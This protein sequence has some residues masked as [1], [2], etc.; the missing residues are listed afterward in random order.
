MKVLLIEPDMA[1]HGKMA[2]KFG[3]NLST[4]ETEEW[5]RNLC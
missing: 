5:G 1:I 4:T 3:I 2:T